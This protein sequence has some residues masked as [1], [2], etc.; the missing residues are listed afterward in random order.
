M[1]NGSR[2]TIREGERENARGA[3]V[4]SRSRRGFK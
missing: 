1:K 4:L 3:S 2:T